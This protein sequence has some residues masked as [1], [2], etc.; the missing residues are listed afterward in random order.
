[1]GCFRIKKIRFI[2]FDI[3]T[4]MNTQDFVSPVPPDLLQ[5]QVKA[6]PSV[7]FMTRQH[8][9]RLHEALDAEGTVFR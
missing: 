8:Y 3:T 7:A 9:P 1:M 2:S 5:P 6:P 4:V